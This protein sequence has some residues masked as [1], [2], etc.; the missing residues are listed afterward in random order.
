MRGVAEYVMRGRTQ[1]LL[2]AVITAGIPM[3]FWISAAV[4]G[5]VTLRRGLRDGTTI[6]LGALVPGLIVGWY[7]EIMP[8]PALVGVTLLAALLR[9][10]ASWNWTLCAAAMMGLLFGGGLY[11]VGSG[12]LVQVETLLAQ[13]FEGVALPAAENGAAMIVL[14]TAA[15]IAGM[16]GFFLSVTLVI[17]L[18]IA[19][20]WQALLYNPGGFRVE[21]HALRLGPMQVMGLMLVAALLLSMGPTFR[22]WA[23]VAL[24]PMLFSGL[25]LVHAMF[26]AR[27][28][29]GW[30]GLFYAALLFLPPMRQFLVV[31]AAMDGWLDFRRRWHKPPGT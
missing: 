19:R 24:V 14:P 29:S 12:Y 3:F 25:A 2:V 11:T 20:W 17:C 21:F 18:I 8:A 22:L 4:V 9:A 31:L 23:W 1:A 30:M 28:W 26:A 27:G 5:L 13:V 6:L 10:G 7:G 16:F 15:D